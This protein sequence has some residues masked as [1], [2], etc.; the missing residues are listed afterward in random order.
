ML[1]DKQLNTSQQCA[2]MAEKINPILACI[3]NSMALSTREVMV[4]LYSVV[5]RLHPNL[6]YREVSVPTAGR[7]ELNGL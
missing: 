1:V 5:V 7:L 2:W 4:P 6:I 3:R